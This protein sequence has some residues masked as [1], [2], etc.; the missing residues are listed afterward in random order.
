V[1]I[2]E[3]GSELLSFAAPRT[4]KDIEELMKQPSAFDNFVLPELDE[5]KPKAKGE[6]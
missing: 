6:E 5:V 2:T 3:N 1:L 4:V